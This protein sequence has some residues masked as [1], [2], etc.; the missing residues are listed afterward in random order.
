[1]LGRTHII[2]IQYKWKPTRLNSKYSTILAL[3]VSDEFLRGKK[4]KHALLTPLPLVHNGIRGDE[5]D[6]DGPVPRDRSRIQTPERETLVLGTGR[7]MS[8][9]PCWFKY[10]LTWH[11]WLLPKKSHLDM[12]L[13]YQPKEINTFSHGVFIRIKRATICKAPG[14]VSS[15][16][17]KNSPERPPK[18]VICAKIP[19]FMSYLSCP[20]F[21]YSHFF[22]LFIHFLY[23]LGFFPQVYLLFR[24][25]FS[26]LLIWVLPFILTL[27]F[28]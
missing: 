21:I 15:M 5:Q 27:R 9:T 4:L 10:S 28:S 3:Y 1:M 22:L 19:I 11:L 17:V 7:L 2:K 14:M 6:R 24:I 12:G 25:G 20:L 23:F 8:C 16:C 26:E 13:Q 18:I